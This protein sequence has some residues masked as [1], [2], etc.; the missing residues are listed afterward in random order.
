VSGG[1]SSPPRES[2]HSRPMAKVKDGRAE[3][4]REVAERARVGALRAIG[5]LVELIEHEDARIAMAAANTVLDRAL[6]KS[7]AQPIGADDDRP[8]ADEAAAAPTVEAL[9]RLSAD[10]RAELRTLV[11]RAAGRSFEDG[12]PVEPRRRARK[13]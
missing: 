10:D 9:A 1:G 12:P 2:A 4:A 13:P 3:A 7:S 11:A 8:P 5:R 6:G